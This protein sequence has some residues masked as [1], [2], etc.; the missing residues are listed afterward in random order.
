VPWHWNEAGLPVGNQLVAAYGRQDLP[1]QVAGQLE[2]AQPSAHLTP[3]GWTTGAEAAR[4]LAT[5]LDMKRPVALFVP[6]L[7]LGACSG[8]DGDVALEEQLDSDGRSDFVDGVMQ[9]AEGM[10]LRDEAQCWGD[11][12][13]AAGATPDDLDRWADDPLS[14]TGT[15]YSTLLADCIDPEADLEVPI[16][17][18][19][20]TSFLGGL[21]EGGLTSIQAECVLDGLE[22]AGFG[23][24]D[25][26]LS[27]VLPEAQTA[28]G[29]AFDA[30]F[31]DCI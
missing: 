12:I 1:I 25:L 7:I 16:E 3:P 26:F 27:G 29:D 9:G 10:I 6:L 18:L 8:I 24:R 4:G 23:G 2:T 14:A 5:V 20:R 17:G 28:L 11:A 13:V 22:A 21:E 19:M 30:L 15:D 31:G